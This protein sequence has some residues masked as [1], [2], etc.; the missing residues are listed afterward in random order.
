MFI[1]GCSSIPAK[2]PSHMIGYKE[3]GNASFYAMKYQFRETASGDRFNQLADTA[4]HKKLPFGTKVK[5]T[6]TKNGKSIVVKINDRGPFIKGRIIDLTRS[7]FS[8]IGNTDSGV[9]SVT[10]EVVK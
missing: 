7:A 6:N 3:S 5:V 8:A 2:S 10:I 9:I 1:L 4:A